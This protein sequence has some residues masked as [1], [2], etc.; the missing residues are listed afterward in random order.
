MEIKP[1]VD[2]E[3]KREEKVL[4]MLLEVINILGGPKRIAE[5]RTLTWIPSI[6]K[7]SYALLL[8]DI[9]KTTD[10]IARELGLTKATVQRMLRAD[11]KEVFRKVTG[12]LIDEEKFDE[13]VAGGLAKLAFKRLKEKELL[14][15]I[16]RVRETAEILGADWAVHIMTRIK[17]LDFPVEKV[18]LMERLKGL[19]I[20]NIPIEEILEELDYPIKSPS[21]LLH[22]ISVKLKEKGKK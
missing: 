3:K 8:Q 9:G 13:H 21:K 2:I 15:E 10:E 1:P 12:E 20:F 19:V 18:D 14:E 5:F 4:K 16:E 22:A 6:I 11:E 17:G 7:A